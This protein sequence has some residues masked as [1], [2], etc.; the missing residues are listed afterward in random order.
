VKDLNRRE[1]IISASAMGLF[2]ACNL[3]KE[4]KPLVEPTIVDAHVH[5]W[6]SD[7][8]RYPLAP[9]FEPTDLLPTTDC[10]CQFRHLAVYSP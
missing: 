2:G 4:D 10:V 8:R 9:G 1:W 3:P 5:V 6:S 7:F